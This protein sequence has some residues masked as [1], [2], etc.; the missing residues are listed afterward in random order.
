MLVDW[1]T[2]H[3]VTPETLVWREGMENWYPASV[4]VQDAFGDP[5]LSPMVGPAQEAPSES[6]SPIGSIAKQASRG[7]LATAKATLAQK[8]KRKQM[9]NWIVIGLMATIVVALTATLFVILWR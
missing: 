1:I 9:R 3:R 2:E 7:G 6:L 8:R 4:L 5:R